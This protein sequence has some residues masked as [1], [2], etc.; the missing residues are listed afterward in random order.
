MFELGFC[1]ETTM[2]NFIVEVRVCGRRS[3]SDSRCEHVPSRVC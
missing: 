3:P 2:W 1:S